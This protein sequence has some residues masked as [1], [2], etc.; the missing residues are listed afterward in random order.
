VQRARMPK[1]RH[2][3]LP[4]MRNIIAITVLFSLILATN[5]WIIADG[6][7]LDQFTRSIRRAARCSNPT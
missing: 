3:T 5:P 4:M 6:I 1:F 7:T 2:I